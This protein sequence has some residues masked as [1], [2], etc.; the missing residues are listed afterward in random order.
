MAVNNY[1]APGVSLGSGLPK[2]NETDGA[3]VTHDPQVSNSVLSRKTLEAEIRGFWA[4]HNASLGEPCGE[5][6]PSPWIVA[7]R[8][9]YDAKSNPNDILASTMRHFAVEFS[10]EDTRIEDMLKTNPKN[11]MSETEKEPTSLDEAIKVA[12]KKEQE[13]DAW[14]RIGKKYK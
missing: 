9:N 6:E 3:W 11:N 10:D 13:T 5:D 12:I 1:K 4:K 7:N 14:S 8:L 2:D